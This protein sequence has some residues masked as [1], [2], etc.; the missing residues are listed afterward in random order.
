MLAHTAAANIIRTEILLRRPENRSSTTPAATRPDGRTSAWHPIPASWSEESVTPVCDFPLRPTYREVTACGGTFPDTETYLHGSYT[1]ISSVSSAACAAQ[2]PHL[3]ESGTFFIAPGLTDGTRA[4]CGPGRQ[5]RQPM[6][7]SPQLHLTG[8]TAAS[9]R[10]HSGTSSCPLPSPPSLVP[11]SRS[12]LSPTPAPLG[13][14][15]WP[16]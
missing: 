6:A 5:R 15:S 2:A 16:S 8:T 10:H 3:P 12:L 14:T 11:F 1:P 9:L 7:G 4:D 13:T